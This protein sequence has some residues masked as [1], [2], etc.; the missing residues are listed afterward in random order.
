MD[1]ELLRFAQLAVTV[2]RRVA[3]TPSRFA[4][5]TYAPASLFALLLL[6]ERLRLTYRGL[7]DLLRLSD[8]L[9]RLL[10][11]R[12]VPD[13][14]TVWRFARRHAGPDLLDAALNETV[15]RARGGTERA[16]QIALDSTGLFLA[17]TSRYFEWRA[18]RH[19]GQRGWL[20]WAFAM[21]VAPQILLA[22]RVRPGPCGDFTDL[23]PLASAAA[24]RMPFEQLLADAGYD[25]E[26]NHRHCREG[27]GV[28]S[29]I[30]AKKRRSARVVAT[31]PLRQE[32]V[33][34]LGKPD[35]EADRVAYRQRW[36]VETVMSVVKRCHG[37]ALTAKLDPTQR[38]QALLRGLTYNLQRL[39]RL[40][41]PA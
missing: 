25:S 2:A 13:H 26:A 8:Q 24:S 15:R 6:R 41:A 5:P 7:E 21:W 19:R 23:P 29:L 30:P 4:T 18:K 9:R 34:R 22:Q 35:V 17:H 14:A 3:P 28:D 12:A 31:T 20:K 33:R 27:L 1:N 40:G 32:M 11:L 36:K 10:G 37:E 39:V 38:V 16:S